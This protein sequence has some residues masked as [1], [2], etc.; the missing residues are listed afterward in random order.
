MC[1]IFVL[2]LYIK[3]K[4][5]LQAIFPSLFICLFATPVRVSWSYEWYRLSGTSRE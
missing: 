2:M 1:N 5:S 3:M 4:L